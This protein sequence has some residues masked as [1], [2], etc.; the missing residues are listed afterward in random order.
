[1]S[2]LRRMTTAVRTSRPGGVVVV[3]IAAALLASGA[4]TFGAFT[5]TWGVSTSLAS[6]PDW[7]PPVINATVAG[8]TSGSAT[9]HLKRG[10][11]YHLYADVAADRGNPAAGVASVTA[12]ASGLTAGQTAVALTAGS[13]SFG[14]VSYNYRSA[15]LTVDTTPPACRYSHPTTVTDAATPANTATRPGLAPLTDRDLLTDANIRLDGPAAG[16]LIGSVDSAGDVNSDGKDDVIVGNPNAD[17]NSRAD[18]GSAYVIFGRATGVTI[19]LANIGTNGFRVDGAAANDKAGASV[20]AAGDVNGDGF[21]DVAVTAPGADNNSRSNSGSAYVVFGSTS[22]TTIDLNVLGASAG[23]RI[24]GASSSGRLGD[25]VANTGDANGDGKPDVVVGEKDMDRAFVV[26]GKN[27]G[28]AVDLNGITEFSPAKGYRLSGVS[29]GA[30]GKSVSGAGDVNKDGYADTL[31]GSFKESRNGRSASGSVYLV[32]GKTTA[33]TVD[34]NTYTTGF[35]VDGATNSKLGGSVAPAGDVNADGTPDLLMVAHDSNG[36]VGAERTQSGSAYVIFGKSTTSSVD[37]T[38]LGAAGYHI[39]GAVAGDRVASVA[40]IGDVDG[41]GRADALVTAERADPSGRTDAGAAYV[42]FGKSDTAVVDLLSLGSRGYSV[43]GAVAGD[44][45]GDRASA[46]GDINGDGRMDFIINAPGA[47][48]NGRTD[49]GSAVVVHGPTCMAANYGTAPLATPGLT[50]YWPM[51]E[52]SGTMA[53]DVKG[54]VPNEG[55]YTG[56]PTLGVSGRFSPTDKAVS[57][58]GVDDYVNFRN[59]TAFQITT[60]TVEAWVKTSAAGASYRG[61]LVK[62]SAY[63]MFL[64][65]GVLMAYDWGA[66]ADRSTGVNLADGQW[67]HVVMTFSS[68][69]A[70]GTRIYS[71]GVLRLT[72][73]TT[74]SNNTNQLQVAANNATQ[75]FAGSIDEP[76]IYDRVLTAAQITSNYNA[77]SNACETYPPFRNAVWCTSGLTN[78]WRLGEAAAATTAMDATGAN[79]G[80]YGGGLTLASSGA[81]PNDPDT[82]P[83][84]DGTDDTVTLTGLTGVNRAAGAYNTVEFWMYWT[85]TNNQMPFGFNAYDLYFASQGFG[86]NTGAGD[87]W[88]ISTAGLAN[89]WVHVAAAFYNGD[90]KKSRL[91]IDGAEQTLTQRRNT[92]G[93]ATATTSARI[94]GWATDTGYKFG[95]KIDEVAVYNRLLTT[96]EVLSHYLAR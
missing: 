5:A 8:S 51:S 31:I 7:L 16:D 19:D 40:G 41:D 15:M 68:G 39:A 54:L 9:E 20:S 47:D 83:T 46:A 32:H 56:G 21:D 11:T 14:G 78:Y 61:I 65:D 95:G 48:N 28:A 67:H 49:S 55:T 44:V 87:V 70:N 84:F 13:Y 37:V 81:L 35:R 64:K 17:N 59:P 69:V 60:G 86:F 24:D 58:D 63:G 79:Q 43:A 25:S 76:A 53:N 89:R 82:A 50:S 85:G 74:V 36:V 26:F 91:W 62:N 29:G 1:M 73:T 96:G 94:S 23:Y 34:L 57:F 52:G 2:A 45:S 10:S 72:T 66:G 77:R 90:A 88:G 12:D 71:D 42:V 75:F 18:S 80:T 6:H 4:G 38:A 33:A 30:T 22:P 93:S 92:T 3:L 27:D